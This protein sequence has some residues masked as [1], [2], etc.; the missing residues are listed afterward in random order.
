M[1]YVCLSMF[2]YVHS[3]LQNDSTLKVLLLS[4]LLTVEER[5]LD[6]L[7]LQILLALK[8]KGGY[9]ENNFGANFYESEILNQK[10]V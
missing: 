5:R 7:V 1:P 4:S 9:H 2:N 6:N 10:N 3:V 8:L